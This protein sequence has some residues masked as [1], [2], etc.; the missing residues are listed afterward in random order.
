MEKTKILTEMFKEFGSNAQAALDF[1][2][3]PANRRKLDVDLPVI[4]TTRR[5]SEPETLIALE[6]SRY[7]TKEQWNSGRYPRKEAVGVAVCTPL[8]S[9]IVSQHQW[10]ACW[11]KDTDHVITKKHTEAQAIQVAS[12]LEAT[13]QIVDAQQS[14]DETAAKICWN[15]GFKN[16]QWYLPSLLELGIM[17]A[18]KK[19]INELMAL[20][21]G[22]SL[23]FDL[24]YWSSTEYSQYYSWHVY[25]DSGSFG[26]YGKYY[27]N[28]VR[29][30]AAF[31]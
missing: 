25:F 7:V 13:K 17:C 9:F 24:F 15:Y 21:G 22:T 1:I 4:S 28:V 6:G 5:S 30:V 2:S 3:N 12:G 16:L 20:I 18:Y 26:G 19:E 11:S 27:G 23:E 10:E 29:A 8:V 31:S 14:E